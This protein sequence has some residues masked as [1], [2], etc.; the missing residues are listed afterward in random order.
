MGQGN[1]FSPV[2]HGYVNSKWCADAPESYTTRIQWLWWRPQLRADEQENEG[3]AEDLAGSEGFY[4][5][6]EMRTLKYLASH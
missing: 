4:L 2:Y 5:D 1:P 3:V 6:R